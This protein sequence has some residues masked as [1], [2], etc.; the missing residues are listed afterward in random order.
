MVE[1]F[2]IKKHDFFNLVMNILNM[3]GKE[4]DKA[5]LIRNIV[6]DTLLDSENESDLSQE[7]AMMQIWSDANRSEPTVTLK[8][9]KQIDWEQP[10]GAVIRQ[11]SILADRL[12]LSP[13]ESHHQYSDANGRRFICTK[14]GFTPMNA[15]ESMINIGEYP[16]SKADHLQARLDDFSEF[17]RNLLGQWLARAG[18]ES[19][20]SRVTKTMQKRI[21]QI[22]H[23]EE[24]T[25]E[26]T[27][28]PQASEH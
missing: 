23:F 7:K 18:I 19:D 2:V 17:A 22:K 6:F 5:D 1:G 28:D 4:H 14:Y 16:G 20:L 21:D 26:K 10:S 15:P 8:D 27:G 25:T 3:P 24:S 12:G 11:L 13:S 9:V